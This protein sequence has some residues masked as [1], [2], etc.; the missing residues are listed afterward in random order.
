MNLKRVILAG[1]V[2]GLLSLTNG[3]IPPQFNHVPIKSLF[4]KPRASVETETGSLAA[5]ESSGPV[6]Y[7]DRDS[8]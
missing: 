4:T 1:T 6:L 8:L 7:T 3:C 5:A 2:L